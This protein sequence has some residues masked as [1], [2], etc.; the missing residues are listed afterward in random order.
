M[1]TEALRRLRRIRE[2]KE[3]DILPVG[4][5]HKQLW[6]DT[7]VLSVT[8]ADISPNVTWGHSSQKLF[9]HRPWLFLS[10]KVNGKTTR[11]KLISVK[12]TETDRQ[13]GRARK[14]KKE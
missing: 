4:S 1:P 12:R 7:N 3:R 8:A 11:D 9:D 6:V 14:E 5:D 13:T 10:R 2:Q